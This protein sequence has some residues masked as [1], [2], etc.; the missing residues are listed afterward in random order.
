MDFVVNKNKNPQAYIYRL[1]GKL[2]FYLEFDRFDMVW[3]W[4]SDITWWGIIF[5]CTPLENQLKKERQFE[6]IEEGQAKG[7]LLKVPL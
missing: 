3:Y 7:Q 1:V 2:D 6:L 4:G 5:K